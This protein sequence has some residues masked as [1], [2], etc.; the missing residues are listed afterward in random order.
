MKTKQF[1]NKKPE[2]VHVFKL[3]LK[4]NGYSDNAIDELWKWYDYTE[5]K[6]IA[7]Y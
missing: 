5:K 4:E 3:L 7:T 2:Q 6:G 1:C